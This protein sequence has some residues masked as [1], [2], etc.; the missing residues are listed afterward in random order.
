MKSVHLHWF[1]SDEQFNFY[2]QYGGHIDDMYLHQHAD[3]TEL[4]IVLHGNA[5]HIVNSEQSFIKKGDVFVINGSTSHAYKD[6]HEFRICNIMYKT[7]ML[8]SAGPDVQKCSG[9]KALFILEPFYRNIHYFTSKLTLPISSLEYISSL[10]AFMI[11]EYET[12]QPGYQTMIRS[13]FMELVVHLSRQYEN[14]EQQGVQGHLIHLANAI[15]LMEDNYLKPLT[16][17]EIAA[18]SNISVRH[19]NRIFRSYYQTTPFAYLQRL[20][21]EHACAL[22]KNTVFPVSEISG[23]SGFNDSNYFTRQFT[24]VMGVSPKRYRNNQAVSSPGSGQERTDLE[25]KKAAP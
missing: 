19:L 6:P 7:E 3:F 5:T 24:K 13:R 10:V 9:Y 14:Q 25:T 20:R 2:I 1:T 17:E 16:R 23:L 15:S 21:L 12:R 4:V 18:K 8:Q 11:Q 22:L